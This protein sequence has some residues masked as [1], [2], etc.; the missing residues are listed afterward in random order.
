MRM[1]SSKEFMGLSNGPLVRLFIRSKLAASCCCP[2]NDGGVLGK[3]HQIYFWL[4]DFCT[5]RKCVGAPV[6]VC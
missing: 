4:G 1:L 2:L 5:A 3:T 6:S